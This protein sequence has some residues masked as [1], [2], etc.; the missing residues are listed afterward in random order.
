M[1]QALHYTG[2]WIAFSIGFHSLPSF[3]EAYA[4][5]NALLDPKVPWWLEALLT[6]WVGLIY[7]ASLGSLFELDILYA[8][9][10]IWIAALMVLQKNSLFPGYSR[11]SQILSCM[12]IR[13]IFSVFP[14]VFFKVI[15][16]YPTYLGRFRSHQENQGNTASP[17]QHQYHSVQI[18]PLG[19]GMNTGAQASY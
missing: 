17:K 16:V 9:G 2:L 3:E 4:M 5:W 19:K 8:L 15:L 1:F 7:L 14:F 11:S 6:P 10:L 18:L 13:S 12:G